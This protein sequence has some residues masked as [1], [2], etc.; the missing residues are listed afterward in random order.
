MT[1][2]PG[3]AVSL[4]QNRPMGRQ[5][6]GL[7]ALL[8]A[9]CV[10][11]VVPNLAPQ[12]IRGAATLSPPP[13]PPVAGSCVLQAFD[14]TSVAL[15][16]PTGLQPVYPQPSTGPC[17]GQG[18][19]YG[20]ISAVIADPSYPLLLDSSGQDPTD[21]RCPGAGPAEDL[22]AGSDAGTSYGHWHVGLLTATVVIEPTARQAAAGQHW[23]A[24]AI[25]VTQSRSTTVSPYLLN[26]AR[27]LSAPISQ[28]RRSRPVAQAVGQCLITSSSIDSTT[29]CSITHAAESFGD[30]TSPLTRSLIDS[31]RILIG[32]LTGMPDPTAGGRLHLQVLSYDTNGNQVTATAQ[33]TST[34]TG[35]VCMIDGGGRT[36]LKDTLLALGDQ[37][38]PFG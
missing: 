4:R 20:Q 29:D 5:G 28:W 24:C 10:A 14:L 30:T 1:F 22:P 7:V 2:D 17:H 3:G 38:V 9:L 32:N 16:G 35:Q 21:A 15:S 13:P 27:G 34:D 33:Q 36:Y 6:T 26:Q 18:V 31:C 12:R 23:L 8:L 11:I 25:A 37:P 19:V